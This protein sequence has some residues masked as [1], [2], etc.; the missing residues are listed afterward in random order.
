MIRKSCINCIH[1]YADPEYGYNCDEEEFP[2][3]N[4]CEKYSVD[5]EYLRRE[6]EQFIKMMQTEQE[7]R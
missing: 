3:V 7:G 6:T 4:S 5:E 2:N 1:A